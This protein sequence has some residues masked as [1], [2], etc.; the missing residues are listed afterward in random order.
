[1]CVLVCFVFSSRRRHTRC[2][3]VTGVQTG[4]LPISNGGFH[5]GTEIVDE[6]RV[7]SGEIIVQAV[8]GSFKRRLLKNWVASALRLEARHDDTVSFTG[9]AL[10]VSTRPPLPISID[11]EVLAETPVT[12][13]IAAG[14]IEVTVPA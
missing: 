3:L 2:A 11:G 9:K 10:R 1:M 14:V 12:A 5:G 4:A 6:A 8:T 13:R 7:E